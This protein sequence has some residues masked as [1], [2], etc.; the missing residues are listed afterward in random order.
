MSSDENKTSATYSQYMIVH[1]T[2]PE[3][4][5]KNIETLLFRGWIPLGGV[6]VVQT[7]D[8]G[9]FMAQAVVWPADRPILESRDY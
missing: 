1:N 8:G 3:G 5:E 2:R 9:F 6:T 4:F 7:A